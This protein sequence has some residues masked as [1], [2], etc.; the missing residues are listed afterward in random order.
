IVTS[1]ARYSYAAEAPFLEAARRRGPGVVRVTLHVT[2]GVVS[3]GVLRKDRSAFV[4]YRTVAAGG[5]SVDVYLPVPSLVEAG[6]LMITNAAGTPGERSV[7]DVE[8]VVVLGPA[9]AH[10]TRETRP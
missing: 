9:E 1:G 2:S 4:V 7:L 6:T 8:N 5:K 3:I 10:P